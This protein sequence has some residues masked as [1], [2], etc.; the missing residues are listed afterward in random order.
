MGVTAAC[1][2][3]HHFSNQVTTAVF[4][5]VHGIHAIE[6]GANSLDFLPTGGLCKKH[7]IYMRVYSFVSSRAS[8]QVASVQGVADIRQFPCKRDIH[9]SDPMRRKRR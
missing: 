5:A 4:R 6:R 7:T 1:K 3:Q 2:Q 9:Q 8:L